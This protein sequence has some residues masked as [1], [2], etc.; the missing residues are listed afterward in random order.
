ML[1][2]ATV[3]TLAITRALAP[4]SAV[5]FVCNSTVHKEDTCPVKKL[6]PPAA[7]LVGSGIKDLEFLHVEIPE[8]NGL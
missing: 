3:E 5:C 7:R 2:A 4:K 6:P 8:G 1:S